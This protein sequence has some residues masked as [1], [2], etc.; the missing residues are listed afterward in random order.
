MTGIETRSIEPVPAAARHGRVDDQGP[1]WFVG[2]FHFFTVSIGFIGPSLGLGFAASALAATLGVLFGTLFMA[3]HASQ[4]PELGLPQMIQSRAQFGYKGVLV[5]LFGALFTFLGFNVINTIIVVEGLE[6]LWRSDPLLV[7][8][9]LAVIAAVLAVWGHDWLHGAFK[10]LFWI[11]LP[12]FTALTGAILLGLVPARAAPP[13]ETFGLAAFFTQFAAA[14]SYNI[15]YAPYVSDYSRYL[16][17]TTPRWRII[18]NVYAGAGISAIWLI[19]LGAWLATHIGARDSVGALVIAGDAIVPGFGLAL[20]LASIGALVATM[21]INAYSGMLTIVTGLDSLGAVTPGRSLRIA[22]ILLLAALWLAI[23]AA[24]GGDAIGALNATL[25]AMLY[26]LAPWT[27]INLVDYF[28][29]RKGRYAIADL[30]RPGG[31]YGDWSRRGLVAYF[32]GLTASVPFFAIHGVWTGP[33][34]RAL[35][36]VD[37]AWAAGLAVSALAYALASRDF[38]IGSEAAAITASAA[39]LP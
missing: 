21:G 15:T 6:T 30:V 33:A 23:A 18:A 39:A 16:P 25:I 13:A 10:A 26:L 35:G 17:E 22:I 20:A 5:P 34:A 9:L 24:F 29:L 2:N 11:G 36:G 14:A 8:A 27:A 19:A 3:F 12:L 7:S 31:I 4:G 1:F 38:D 37:I 28:W 32:A